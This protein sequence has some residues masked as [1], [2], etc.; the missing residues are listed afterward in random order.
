[1]SATLKSDLEQLF[2]KSIE[3]ISTE[4]MYNLAPFSKRDYYPSCQ[5]CLSKPDYNAMFNAFGEISPTHREL[6]IG[7]FKH[8][9]FCHA[10]L[11]QIAAVTERFHQV[12]PAALRPSSTPVACSDEAPSLY[13]SA[14]SKICQYHVAQIE[15]YIQGGMVEEGLASFVYLIPAGV[16]RDYLIVYVDKASDGY[17]Q[18]SALDEKRCTVTIKKVD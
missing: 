8:E 18:M 15:S 10:K 7:Q 4:D 11:N 17:F 3:H 6:Y 5:L 2:D 16:V 13:K 14:I 12:A 9:L 1:M